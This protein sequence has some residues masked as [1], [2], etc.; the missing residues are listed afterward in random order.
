MFNDF[1]LHS[2]LPLLYVKTRFCELTLSQISQSI[3]MLSCSV[4]FFIF[5]CYTELC[6]FVEARAALLLCNELPRENLKVIFF[7]AA[8]LDRFYSN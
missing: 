8:I 3:K 1:D 5:E 6:Y 4:I 7:L 2:G